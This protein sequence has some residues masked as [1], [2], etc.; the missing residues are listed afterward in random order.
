MGF[1]VVTMAFN[2]V[3]HGHCLDDLGCLGFPVKMYTLV[4]PQAISQSHL[5]TRWANAVARQARAVTSLLA[6]RPAYR[7]LNSFVQCEDPTETVL[8]AERWKGDKRPIRCSTWRRTGG[9]SCYPSILTDLGCLGFPP[10]LRKPPNDHYHHIILLLS[11]YYLII[12]VT[13]NCGISYKIIPSSQLSS[14][15]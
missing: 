7:P 14:H 4:A 3:S 6:S 15:Y 8:V 9:G 11:F 5:A 13:N 10:W 1:P 2:T 12:P